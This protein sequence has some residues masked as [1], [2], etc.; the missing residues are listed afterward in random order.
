MPRERIDMSIEYVSDSEFE[1]RVLGSKRPVVVLLTLESDLDQKMSRIIGRI[2]ADRGDEAEFLAVKLSESPLLAERFGPSPTPRV[3]VFAGGNAVAQLVGVHAR[4]SIC[5]EIDKVVSRPVD[6]L[7]VL[8]EEDLKVRVSAGGEWS[9][10]V[11]S[12]LI[13]GVAFGFA[14]HYLSGVLILMIPA[15]AV[16]LFILND[17]FRFSWSQKLVAIALM[18]VVGLFGPDFLKWAY[19]Q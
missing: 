5:K 6:E 8:R 18:L 10:A 14:L 3:L 2:A 16:G 17:N 7:P 11:T 13:A 1:E 12:G 4:E 19:T 15:F 9:N